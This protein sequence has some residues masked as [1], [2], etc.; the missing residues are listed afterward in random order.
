MKIAGLAC[1]CAVS[2]IMTACG[3]GG[4]S[5]SGNGGGGGNNGGGGG[6]NTSITVSVAPA[7]ATV[8]LNG[9]QQFSATVTPSTAQQTVTWRVVAGTGTTCTSSA[10]GTVDGNGLYTGPASLPAGSP[11][12]VKV[13][14]TSTQDTSKSDS[15]TVTLVSSQNSRVQG[16]YTFRFSGFNAAGQ[17]LAV[18]NFVADGSGNITSGSEDISTSSGPMPTTTITGGAYSIGSDGRGGMMLNTSLGTF[19]YVFAVGSTT[20]DNPLFIEFDQTTS[21]IACTGTQLGSGTHGSGLMN[22]ATN[23]SFNNSA[24]NRP[25]VFGLNGYDAS[26]HRAAYAGQFVG[27]GAGNITSWSLDMNDNGVATATSGTSGT[28][29]VSSSGVGTLTLNASPNPLNLNLF[30]KNSDEIFF[31]VADPLIT[32]PSAAGVAESQ[33]TSQL[34]D[35]S[36]FNATSVFYVTGVGS[37]ASQGRVIAG[38]E[39]ATGA[40]SLS[41]SLDQNN[42]GAISSNVT[43]NGAYSATGSGRYTIMLNNMPFVM[44]AITANKGFLL[45]QS[46]TSFL[47]GVFE[48]QTTK[49]INASTIGGSFVQT[50]QQVSTAWAQDTVAAVMLNNS[51]G[52]ISGTQ[53]ETDGSETPNQAVAGS[54][55]VSSNGR[56]SFNLTSPA[57]STGVLYV[58]G[59]SKFV[60]IPVDSSNLNPLV[61][62]NGH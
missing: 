35:N 33:D 38:L 55:T 57:A 41:G 59:Q 31:S 24:L 21:P 9:A 7:A 32:N 3:G 13:I 27:D 30:M 42:A 40:G 10:C 48:P 56:G 2:L 34:Y 54:Y 58:I 50:A 52:A 53:D 16:T 28:Y 8:A 22:L 46:S 12:T 4:G 25:Y 47:S 18:G 19:C 14:A 39:A 36:T 61:L 17:V 20:I 15:A 60:V 23:S 29:S 1:L 51:I 49:P 6:G 11:P 37:N 45:D 62:I 44:Y 5:S 26:G 43:F